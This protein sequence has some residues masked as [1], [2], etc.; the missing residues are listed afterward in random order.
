MTSEVTVFF[1][2]FAVGSALTCALTW[3][4]I[5]GWQKAA[6]EWQRA[7]NMMKEAYDA[8]RQYIR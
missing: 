6:E 8:Q 1:L 3:R 4:A 2:G 5:Y 7:Y